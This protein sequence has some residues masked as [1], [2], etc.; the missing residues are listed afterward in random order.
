MIPKNGNW[1]TGGGSASTF[2]LPHLFVFVAG[3][4]RKSSWEEYLRRLGESFRLVDDPP[5]VPNVVRLF[6]AVE[7]EGA[8]P[9]SLLVSPWSPA[10]YG[11]SLWSGVFHLWL[12][13]LSFCGVLGGGVAT[14]MGTGGVA[15]SVSAYGIDF[16][17]PRLAGPWDGL[18][19]FMT[20]L[21]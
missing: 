4:V 13:I 9:E 5:S 16:R 19:F 1:G 2:G 12:R 8:S 7:L 20:Q 3:K 6:L 10:W 15:A 14:V 18:V 17:L 21:R 11:E